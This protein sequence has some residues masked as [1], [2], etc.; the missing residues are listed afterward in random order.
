M[1]KACYY[2]K[3]DEFFFVWLKNVRVKKTHGDLQNTITWTKK[4]RKGRQ[5]WEQACSENGM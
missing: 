1:F 4:S 3:N 5:E 2:A